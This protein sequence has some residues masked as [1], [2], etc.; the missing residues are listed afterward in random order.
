MK[1]ETLS[2]EQVS[3]IKVYKGSNK[4]I[5]DS[6]KVI[7]G[8]DLFKNISE[9]VTTFE[10]ACE[11]EGVDPKILFNENDTPDEIAYKKLKVIRNALVGKWRPDW[12]NSN[13]VKYWPVFDMRTS[14]GFGFSH[15]LYG[16]WRTRAR[17]PA[18]AFASQPKSLQ[19]TPERLSWL[20]TKIL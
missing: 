10:E 15:S 20:N 11:V 5:Q 18:P 16:H 4:E 14:S 13:Q 7:F 9:R 2:Q 3:A 1:T 12:N 6:L 19:N 17:L 8:E